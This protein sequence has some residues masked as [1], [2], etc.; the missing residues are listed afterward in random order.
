MVQNLPSD[1]LRPLV[2]ALL[3][4]AIVLASTAIL[5]SLLGIFVIWLGIV[6]VLVTA[7]VIADLAHRSM[8]WLAPAPVG[9][10]QRRAVGVSGR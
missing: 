9:P 4:P 3:A 5:L 7:I 6:A 8:R 1:L 10:L 2:V